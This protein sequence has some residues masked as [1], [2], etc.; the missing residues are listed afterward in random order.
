MTVLAPW[1][2]SWTRSKAKSTARSMSG[3]WIRYRSASTAR[4]GAWTRSR[5]WYRSAA[6]YMDRSSS[7]VQ[8]G[9]T[10]GGSE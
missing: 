1:F 5:A 2:G 7:W 6:R 3:S 8:C 10:V 9:S 4:T